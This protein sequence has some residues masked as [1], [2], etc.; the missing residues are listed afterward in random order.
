MNHGVN[1]EDQLAREHAEYMHGRRCAAHFDGLAAKHGLRRPFSAEEVR[2]SGSSPA[3][4][5]PPQS[6]LPDEERPELV[7]GCDRR[8]SSQLRFLPAVRRS[9]PQPDGPPRGADG[10]ERECKREVETE[11]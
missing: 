9:Y 3:G 8:A 7:P 4:A 10:L 2:A 1:V 6:S 5:P 11:Y